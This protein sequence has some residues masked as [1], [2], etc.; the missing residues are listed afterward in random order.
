MSYEKID[1]DNIVENI[2]KTLN[3][4]LAGIAETQPFSGNQIQLASQGNK[5]DSFGQTTG[6][7][8]DTPIVA[9]ITNLDEDGVPTLAFDRISL[10]SSLTIVDYII[11]IVNVDLKFINFKPAFGTHVK[12][13]PKVGRTLVIK[14]GGDFTNSSDI[15]I[16]DGEYLECVFYNATESG[17]V[18]GGFKPHKIGTTGGGGEFFG[19]W[20]ADH[21]AGGFNLYNSTGVFFDASFNKGIL[22]NAGG[23]GL[24]APIGDTIDFFINSLIIPKFGVTETSIESNVDLDMNNKDVRGVAF[25]TFNSGDDIVDDFTLGGISMFLNT[26]NEFRI[27]R[28][29]PQV[30]EFGNQI[31]F[32][33]QLNMND[34]SVAE[35]NSLFF[36]NGHSIQGGVSEFAFLTAAGDVESHYN[37]ITKILEINGS[38]VQMEGAKSI[39]MLDNTSADFLLITQTGGI[40]DFFY[41]GDLKFRESGVDVLTLGG[42]LIQANRDMDML[43]HVI[44]NIFTAEIEENFSAGGVPSRPVNG[45]KLFVREQFADPTKRELR[46]YFPSGNSQLII[47][48]P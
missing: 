39:G 12:F 18:G 28:G 45:C 6:L 27:F 22:M 7:K 44:D 3:D 13:T 31:E 30:A 23:V 16:N 29:I 37:N 36:D 10:G 19:P 43:N 2:N 48:E 42:L 47:S 38:G 34:N 5:G 41:T 11:P 14:T 21:N 26:S 4:T 20:T 24:I 46:G 9:N 1:T 33:N 40:S 17:I 32:F 35:I 25:L 15:T 8:S